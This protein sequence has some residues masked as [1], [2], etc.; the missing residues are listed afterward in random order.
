MKRTVSLARRIFRA[1]TTVAL[2]GAVWVTAAAPVYHG[3]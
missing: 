2:L 3:P 1:T